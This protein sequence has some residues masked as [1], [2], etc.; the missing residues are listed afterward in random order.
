MTISLLVK[1][2]RPLPSDHCH[3]LFISSSEA[4]RL[5]Q[6]LKTLQGASSLP[7]VKWT[8]Y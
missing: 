8:F 1:L 4:A 5:P 6:I 7:S 2:F 3:I